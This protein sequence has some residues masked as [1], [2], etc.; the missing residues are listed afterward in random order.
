MSVSYF[1]YCFQLS[2]RIGPL[3]HTQTSKHKLSLIQETVKIWSFLSSHHHYMLPFSSSLIHYPWITFSS[4]SWPLNNGHALEDSQDI[5]CEKALLM[6]FLWWLAGWPS[7]SFCVTSRA[8]LAFILS[9]F[10]SNILLLDRLTNFFIGGD[11]H[12]TWLWNHPL[13]KVDWST[14]RLAITKENKET[15]EQ[16]AFSDSINIQL[17]KESRTAKL[18]LER[19]TRI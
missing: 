11:R 1:K 8:I 7:G 5:L 15:L 4:L 10:Q 2:A 9:F 6:H 14:E 16:F 19:K 18:P 13:K 12:H 3:G 17:S